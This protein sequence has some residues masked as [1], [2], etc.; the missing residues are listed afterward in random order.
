ML[1]LRL[2]AVPKKRGAPTR[3]ALRAS[4][5]GG[6]KT[7]PSAAKHSQRRSSKRF[8]E[9]AVPF[10]DSDQETP[11]ASSSYDGFYAWKRFEKGDQAP[12][13]SPYLIPLP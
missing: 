1:F 12:E 6:A 7:R 13:F 5:R 10:V 3:L 4:C 2:R 11:L 8:F 9:K